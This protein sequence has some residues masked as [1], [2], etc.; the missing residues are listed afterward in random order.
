[1]VI[2]LI[3]FFFI[4]DFPEQ[5]TFL[6]KEEKEFVKARLQE[7]VGD[8]GIHEK[9]TMKDVWD[10]LTDYRLI[11]GVLMYLGSIVTAYG[12][13]APVFTQSPL[14]IL[15]TCYQ[16]MHTLPLLLSAAMD[17]TVSP[18]SF[19]HGSWLVS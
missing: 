2:A 19:L 4:A 18:C 14:Q 12:I 8:S 17:M 11:I 5:A 3:F 9:V 7:D 10:A 6:T 13:S 1:M 15:I 16:V